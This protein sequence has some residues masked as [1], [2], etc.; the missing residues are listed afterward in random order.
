MAKPI[1]A[2]YRLQM[3]PQFPFSAAAECL[4]YLARLGVSYVYLSPIWQAAP[5]STHGYDVLDHGAISESLGGLPQ[6]VEFAMAAR[7]HDLRL[8]ADIVPNHVFVGGARQAWWRDVLRFGRNSQ[9]APYFDIDWS[10]RADVPEGVLVLPVLAEPFGRFLEAGKFSL[11][12]SDGEVTVGYEGQTFPVRPTSY[13]DLLGIPAAEAVAG[14]N[15]GLVAALGLIED[16]RRANAE[17]AGPLLREFG[18][19]LERSPAVGAWVGSRLAEVSGKVGDPASFEALEALLT[20]QHYRF[21]YWR[22]SGERV[23]YRRFFDINDLAALRMEYEPAFQDTHRL[24]AQL[25][26][27]GYLSGLRVDHLDG[28]SDPARY[29]GALKTLCPGV[30]VWVE[31]ILSGAEELPRWPI[32]GTTGYEFA[33]A[34]E[35]LFEGGAGRGELVE[36]YREFTGEQD[37][38]GELAFEAR[39]WI[40]DRAFDGDITGL[41]LDFQRLAQDSRLHRDITLRSIREALTAFLACMPQYRTY[42]QGDVPSRADRTAIAQA[43]REA[44]ER[45]SDVVP[46]ALQFI[47]DELTAPALEIDARSQRRRDL[48]RKVQQVSAPVMAKGVEDTTFFRYVPYLC[49]NEVGNSPATAPKSADELHA[50]FAARQR[51]WPNGLSATTTHDTKRSEDARMRIAALANRPRDWRREIRLWS[52]LSSRAVE[53][54]GTGAGVSPKTEYYL[55]QTLV[56]AWEGEAFPEFVERIRGHMLKASREAKEWTSWLSPDLEGEARLDAFVRTILDKRKGAKFLTRLDAFVESLRGDSTANSLGLLALKCLAPGVPDFYQGGE[57][58]LFTL[59]DPDNRRAVDFAALASA[60]GTDECGGDSKL[61][62]TQ[63]LLRLRATKPALFARGTYEPLGRREEARCEPFAFVRRY[64]A[65]WVGVAVGHGAR[66]WLAENAPADAGQR[67]DWIAAMPC[68]TKQGDA[69]PD[70][71]V[72]VLANFGPAAQ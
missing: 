5:G 20:S 66:E 68:G 27:E 62:M 14:D 59:T 33:S 12:F 58:W 15:E 9:Y 28:L 64:R 19:A 1:R 60:L 30:D 54:M 57:S 18:R 44:L 31:K 53:A 25:C 36:T 21:A 2:T 48:L 34:A 6:F 24:V 49:Q 32:A 13:A 3:T 29:L 26:R 4:P 23:N 45:D 70:A 67:W 69:S 37:D 50:W 16:L 17:T 51:R 61:Q 22:T 42:I 63:R 52:R 40:A 41:A 11:G 46:D 10:G 7:K 8:I 71:R 55:Y 56:G 65:D 72:A 47:V 43:A 39:R 38:Y 35:S